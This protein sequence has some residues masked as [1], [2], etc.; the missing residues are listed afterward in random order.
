MNS[1][2]TCT[3]V[4][5]WS[6]SDGDGR[7]F[8]VSKEVSEDDIFPVATVRDETEIRQWPL[9]GTHSLFLLCQ[10][11]PGRIQLEVGQG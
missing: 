10:P 1:F 9:W 3:I 2:I 4:V 6:T 8:G 7:E 5:R 11:V